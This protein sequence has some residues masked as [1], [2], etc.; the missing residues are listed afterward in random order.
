MVSAL[1]DG[2]EPV[3]RAESTHEADARHWVQAVYRRHF[4]FVWR[5]LR[6]LGLPEA[7]VD[8]AVQDVFIVVYRRRHDFQKERSEKSWLFRIARYVAGNH[9]RTRRRKGQFVELQED[10]APEASERPDRQAELR[11]AASMLARFLQT[12]DE[13]QRNVFVLMEI[14]GASARE[15]ADGLDAKLNTVYSRLRLARTRWEQFVQSCARAG[16]SDD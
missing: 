13:D 3:G 8:D 10:A 2:A 16:G 11:Q 14:G 6:G 1:P 12:L 4:D 15:A 9:H 7:Q 5:T